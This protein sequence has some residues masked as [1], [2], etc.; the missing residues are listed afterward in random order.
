MTTFI[1]ALARQWTREFL[2][3]SARRAVDHPVIVVFAVAVIA[4]ICLALL[5]NSL[6]GGALISDDSHNY[7][8]M[9]EAHATGATHTWDA[10]T[11]RLFR[12]TATLLLPI[13]LLYKIMGPVLIAGQL[14]VAL[15]GAAAAALTAR[16]AHEILSPRWALTAGLAVALLPSQVYWSSQILK[17]PPVWAISAGLALVVAFARDTDVRRLVLCGVGAIVLLTLMGFL[18]LHTLVVLSWALM[19]SGWLGDKQFRLPRGAGAICIGIA[20]PWLFG[21]GPAGWHLITEPTNLAERRYLNAQ[22]A[23]TAIVPTNVAAPEE[24][25]E[26]VEV[27]EQL[28]RLKERAN[29]ADAELDERV[30]GVRQQL[31]PGERRRVNRILVAQNHRLEELR[32]DIHQLLERLAPPTVEEVAAAQDPNLVH[33][34]KGLF[35]MLFEPTPMRG[36]ND[37]TIALARTETLVWYPMLLL[38]LVGLPSGLR[39]LRTL[40]FPLLVGGALLLIYALAEGNIGTAY[41]HRGEFVWIVA[42]L[43]TLG[44]WQLYDGLRRRIRRDERVSMAARLSNELQR[45]LE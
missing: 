34:P 45:P 25:T 11:H 22:G 16:L 21:L 12:D 9:A 33:L 30:E 26:R 41:R 15:L 6:F 37:K 29:E 17:D 36:G 13:S 5:V 44:L 14:Y 40:A 43:A 24:E 7:S 28:E 38:A 20:I 19:L 42:I 2:V 31:D 3:A 23:E 4:R 35:V 27:E 32:R 39:K 10:F 8:V 1:P 18:R